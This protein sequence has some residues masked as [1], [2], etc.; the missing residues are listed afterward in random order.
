MRG[1]W[2]APVEKRGGWPLPEG[3][4]PFVASFAP[5]FDRLRTLYWFASNYDSGPYDSF[6]AAETHPEVELEALDIDIPV[7]RDHGR[8]GAALLRPGF[9]PDLADFLYQ[10]WIALVGIRG[11]EARAREAA[12]QFIALFWRVWDEPGTNKRGEEYSLIEQYGEICFFCDEGR[13]WEIYSKDIGDLDKIAQHILRIEGLRVEW[14]DLHE[15]DS[16][17]EQPRT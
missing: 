1:L 7:E 12:A 17:L 15:R 9:L 10:D 2:I 5:V 14:W 6:S 11:D 4:S 13:S 8:M 16:R 3:A